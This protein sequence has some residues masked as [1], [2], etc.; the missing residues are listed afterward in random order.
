MQALM[1]NIP[2][3]IYFKDTEGRFT[4]VN[5]H[6]PYRAATRAGEG[7]RQDRLRLLHRGPRARRLRRTS[8]GSSAPGRPVIDK[9]EKETYPDGSITWLSTTKVPIFDEGGRVTG[10]VGISRDITER[11]LR[12]RGAH[13][14]RRASRPRAPRR[15][16]PTA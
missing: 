12:G 11:K 15:R 14:A 5:R 16:P 6:A 2:D 8:S 1:D 13:R 7:H 4:R 9:E 3:A 10:I